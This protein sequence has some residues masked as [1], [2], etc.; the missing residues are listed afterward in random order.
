ME[1]RYQFEVVR[2]PGFVRFLRAHRVYG[3]ISVFFN[4][5]VVKDD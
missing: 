2:L 4:V 3:I 1:E 5:E